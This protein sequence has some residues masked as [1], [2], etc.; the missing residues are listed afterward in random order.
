[1]VKYRLLQYG[2][3]GAYNTWY[4]ESLSIS[5]SS[6]TGTEGIWRDNFS[7]G[8]FTHVTEMS[9]YSKYIWHREP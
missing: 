8:G 4:I 1:M 5:D 3:F 6:P 9:S 7:L 2:S